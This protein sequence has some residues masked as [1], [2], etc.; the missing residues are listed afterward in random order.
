M[1]IQPARASIVLL[2]FRA[3]AGQDSVRLTWQTA[4]EINLSG[5]NLARSV[6]PQSDFIQINQSLI[7]AQGTNLLGAIYTFTD[8]QL[9]SNTTY[10]YR[11]EV[12][13]TD[14]SREIYGP[15]QIVTGSNTTAEA[16]LTPGVTPGTGNTPTRTATSRPASNQTPT[17]TPLATAIPTQTSTATNSPTITI[18]PTP[19]DTPTAPVLIV[20]TITPAFQPDFNATETAIVIALSTEL[21]QITPQVTTTPEGEQRILTGNDWLRIVLLVL[22]AAVWM[23]LG[24][25]LYIYLSRLNT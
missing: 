21:S 9:S 17:R 19:T 7:T 10:Y 16:S 13:R 24:I 18:T 23:L 5:F 8:S 22:V 20:D 14:Q 1:I 25:W 3:Q 6:N 11:L 15:L 2:Y 4:G 12:V